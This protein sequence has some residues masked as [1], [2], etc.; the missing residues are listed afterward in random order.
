MDTDSIFLIKTKYGEIY[1]GQYDS[2]SEMLLES[3]MI[4][5]IPT[6]SQQF[7]IMMLP[8]FAPLNKD[9][10]DIDVKNIILAK[11]EPN[12]DLKNQ[13]IAAR[14]N[15]LPSSSPKIIGA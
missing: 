3:Y 5:V 6:G 2:E 13:Y 14:T 9:C 11:S 7:N 12:K 1:I 15:I 8:I 4:Q 10:V